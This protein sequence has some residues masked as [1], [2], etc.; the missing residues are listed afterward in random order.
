MFL[1]VAN[2]DIESFKNNNDWLNIH[3]NNALI[4]ADI[5]NVWKQLLLE[6]KGSFRKITYGDFPSGEEILETLKR[7]KNRLSTIEWN[8]TTHKE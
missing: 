5:D 2:D 7:I 6:Y 3:P 8:I 1:K 4:F